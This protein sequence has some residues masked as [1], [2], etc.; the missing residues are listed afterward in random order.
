MKIIFDFMPENREMSDMI[1]KAAREYIATGI[2]PE[3]FQDIFEIESYE[4]NGEKIAK[5]KF[6]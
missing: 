3:A 5:I 6:I 4:C 2:F 1:G